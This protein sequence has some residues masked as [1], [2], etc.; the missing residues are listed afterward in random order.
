MSGTR[1][2]EA[3]LKRGD[4]HPPFESTPPSF[5]GFL[6]FMSILIT[7]GAG[8]IGANFVLD[9]LAEHNEVTTGDDRRWIERQYAAWT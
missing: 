2:I 5:S 9:W 4:D 7:G 8:F 3:R 1:I 6:D